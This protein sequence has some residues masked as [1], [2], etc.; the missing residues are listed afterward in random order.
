MSMKRLI[1]RLE[2]AKANI[3]DDPVD[4]LNDMADRFEDKVKYEQ[5]HGMGAVNSDTFDNWYET[6][7]FLRELADAMAK[8]KD[9]AAIFNAGKDVMSRKIK[10]HNRMKETGITD[11]FGFEDAIS[12]VRALVGGKK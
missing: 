10:V 11:W 4:V 6:I 5:D 8:G 2:E 7:A 9:A 12:E 1:S 3:G